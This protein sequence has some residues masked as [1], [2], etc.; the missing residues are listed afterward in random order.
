MITEGEFKII[1]GGNTFILHLIHAHKQVKDELYQE[2]M[3]INIDKFL[4][5]F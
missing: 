3:R 4:N 1:G 2:E 5:W